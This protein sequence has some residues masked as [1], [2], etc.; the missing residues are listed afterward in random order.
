MNLYELRGKYKQLVEM[1]EEMDPTLFHDTLDSITDAIEDKAEGYAKVI[2]QFKTDAKALKEE[3]Q[4][5]AKRRQAIETK[6]GILQENLYEAMKE[7]GAEKIKSAQ[8][9]VWIQ[10]N[11][12]SVNITNEALIPEEY[13]IPQEPKLDKKSL[14]EDMQLHGE[15]P[16]AELVQSEGVR[17]R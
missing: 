15:I 8:F 9:T 3:E 4:R 6:I 1:E 12:M 2:N 11:P 17:I 16:G 5:L 14:K 13:F 7:T 10:K